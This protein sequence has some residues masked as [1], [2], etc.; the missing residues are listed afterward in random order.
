MDWDLWVFSFWEDEK[1][2]PALEEAWAETRNEFKSTIPLLHRKSIDEITDWLSQGFVPRDVCKIAAEVWPCEYLESIKDG[3]RNSR[4]AKKTA[5]AKAIKDASIALERALVS[6]SGNTLGE[7]Q[8]GFFPVA[9]E[10][11]GL[12]R[13]PLEIG[14]GNEMELSHLICSDEI[15]PWMSGMT[16]NPFFI[17]AIKALGQAAHFVI[18]NTPPDSGGALSGDY[19]RDGSRAKTRLVLDARSTLKNLGLNCGSHKNGPVSRLAALVHRAA[20]GNSAPW[21]DKYAAMVPRL[22]RDKTG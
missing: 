9:R 14:Q 8:V 20:T 12:P 4:N 15:Q 1:D 7:V 22:E 6:A 5:E 10:K 19:D 16:P 21:A 11:I 17:S 18:E 3:Q 2:F 13:L